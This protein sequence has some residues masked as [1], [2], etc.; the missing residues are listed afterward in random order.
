[1]LANG[2]PAVAASPPFCI[3]R[4][5]LVIKVNSQ[6]ESALTSSDESSNDRSLYGEQS[7][8]MVECRGLLLQHTSGDNRS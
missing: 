2:G 7:L 1:M 3:L 6:E 5:S 4:L 8:K